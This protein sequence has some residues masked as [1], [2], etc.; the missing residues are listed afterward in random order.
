M[1]EIKGWQ[2]DFDSN[3]G[4]Y[5]IGVTKKIDGWTVAIRRTGLYVSKRHSKE[6]YAILSSKHELPRLFAEAMSG[7]KF[8]EN[9]IKKELTK[10]TKLGKL[11]GIDIN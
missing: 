8:S 1:S 9:I 10:L 6:Y 11:L 4:G 5:V 2:I 3:Y 7:Q